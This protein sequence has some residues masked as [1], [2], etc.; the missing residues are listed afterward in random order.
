MFC[1]H[2]HP[3]SRNAPERGRLVDLVP[4]GPSKLARPQRG[5]HEQDEGCLC[6]FA[7]LVAVELRQKRRNISLAER[8]AMA[9]P[10]RLKYLRGLERIGGVCLDKLMRDGIAKDSPQTLKDA[11]CSLSCSARF[12][13]L[14]RVAN[15]SRLNTVARAASRAKERRRSRVTP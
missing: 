15:V 13:G 1:V 5:E 12:D 8:G 11:P 6:R 14:D 7:A 10:A 9:C 2:L 3:R 4:S